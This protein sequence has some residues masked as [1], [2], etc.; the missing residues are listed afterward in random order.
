MSSKITQ[1]FPL[2]SQTFIEE[3]KDSEF[4]KNYFPEKYKAVEKTIKDVINLKTTEDKIVNFFII[5]NSFLKRN[6]EETNIFLQDAHLINSVCFLKDENQ[7]NYNLKVLTSFYI[8]LQNEIKA[9]ELIGKNSSYLYQCQLYI[10]LLPISKNQYEIIEKAQKAAFK[11]KKSD[12]LILKLIKA[13]LKQ[14]LFEIEFLINSLSY[15]EKK[16]EAYIMLSKYYVKKGNIEKSELYIKKAKKSSEKSFKN[17]K[18]KIRNF[19]FKY[20]IPS[21]IKDE[22]TLE[23]ITNI[24]KITSEKLDENLFTISFFYL[25]M[26]NFEKALE[27]LK[28]IKNTHYKLQIYFFI[29]KN[30]KTYNQSKEKI[31][32]KKIDKHKISKN[33]QESILSLK[34]TKEKNSYFL[35]LIKILIKLELFQSC[36]FIIDEY[37][38]FNGK[39]DGYFLLFKAYHE[40]GDKKKYLNCLRKAKKLISKF[41]KTNPLKKVKTEE[42]KHLCAKYLII[43]PD[44]I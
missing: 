4:F 15:N 37:I 24:F 8:K 20:L 28:D 14:D 43:E 2:A 1:K 10:S 35:D 31:S 13:A 30:I 23:E 32:Q 9:L 12:I 18:E 16:V 7:R 40:K 39:T 33:I 6:L 38:T 42:L 29:L 36:H 11:T 27:I 34:K 41:W 5:A 26:F 21:T 19:S 25:K 17:T 22:K 3:V 44:L